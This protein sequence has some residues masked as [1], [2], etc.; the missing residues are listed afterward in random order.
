MLPKLIYNFFI[1]PILWLGFLVCFP[2]VRKVREG[3]IGRIGW[4]KRIRT[5]AQQLPEGKPIWLFHA[6]SVGELEAIRPVIDRITRLGTQ[7]VVITVFSPSA[8][9]IKATLS[10]VELLCYLPF[11]SIWNQRILLTAIKQQLVVIS[12][13]DVWPNLLVAAHQLN[14]PTALI[15]AN[16]HPRSLRVH[17]AFRFF[18]RWVFSEFSGIAAV[19]QQ[20]A[21]RL[22]TL[23]GNGVP[24]QVLGDSRYDRVMERCYRVSPIIADKSNHLAGRIVIV[25]GSSHPAEEQMLVPVIAELIQD[26]PNLFVIWVPHDPESSTL[27][28]LEQQLQANQLTTFRWSEDWA[29]NKQAGVIVD[30]VGILAELYTLGNIAIVGG[31]FDKGVHSVIEPAIF[32]LPVLFGPHYHVSQE[33]NYLIENGGGLVFHNR[34]ELFEILKSLL[35]DPEK[36]HLIGEKAKSVV[37]QN[38]GASDRIVTFLDDLVHD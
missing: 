2:F 14:I 28:S 9:R 4:R 18:H 11:D 30:Q 26:Y 5:W 27:A 33:A 19:S 6:A 38:L 25:V 29:S 24:S 36:C 32:G 15:N 16:F 10:E 8:F 21:E 35:A 31:G 20:H 22:N 13:H 12:K 37:E 1:I 3:M 23:V 17:P 34:N 7:R